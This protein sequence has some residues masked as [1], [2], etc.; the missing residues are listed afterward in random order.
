[1]TQYIVKF[2]H[3]KPIPVV[4]RGSQRNCRTTH[5]RVERMDGQRWS[6]GSTETW[7]PKSCVRVAK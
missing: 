1:M 2:P 7:V 6:D 5:Y 3:E 4:I